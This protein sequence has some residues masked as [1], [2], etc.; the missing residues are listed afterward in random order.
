[1][2]GVSVRHPFPRPGI[3]METVYEFDSGPGADV[4]G[5]LLDCFQQAVGHELPNQLVAV[6]G[7][8]SL[9]LEESGEGLDPAGRA[10]LQRL[11]GLA[12]QSGELVRTL[13]RV[14]RLVRRPVAAE[15]VPLVAAAEEAGAE[16][17]VLCGGTVVEYHVSQA[18]PT[19]WVPRPSLHQA[20]VEL[21]RNAFQAASPG[22]PLR[23][24]LGARVASRG[25][26]VTVA[27]NGRGI[28][29]A[30]VPHLGA[31]F[32]PGRD[33]GGFGFGLFLVRLL[34]AGWGGS[35]RVATAPAAGTAVTFWAP[36]APPVAGPADEHDRPGDAPP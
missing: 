4:S 24:E 15:A 35:L 33:P 29:P 10:L 8:A 2:I 14:G 32:I 21:L 30:L 36:G 11:A 20:L 34:V 27:D 22:R 26:E 5:L 12:Q 17:K 23:V 3:L 19:L 28:S 6:Q 7:L 13:G 25:V 18:L 31:P 1:M 16:A 9:L